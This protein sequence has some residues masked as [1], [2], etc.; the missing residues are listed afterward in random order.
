MAFALGTALLV[1][2]GAAAGVTIVE[3]QSSL[4]RVEHAHDVEVTLADLE[5]ALSTA[6]RAQTGYLTSGDPRFLDQYQTLTP[7][8]QPKLDHIRSLIQDIP[9]HQNW[10]AQLVLLANRRLSLMRA[11]VQKRESRKPGESDDDLQTELTRQRVVVADEMASLFQEMEKRERESSNRRVDISNL[12]LD[13]ILSILG[14]TFAMSIGLLYLNYRF[15][16]S[17]LADRL[18]A[19]K[20]ALESQESL[21]LL[22]T[23]LLHVQDEER[24]QFSREVHDSLGQYLNLVKMSLSALASKR[25]AA[26]LAESMEYL[27]RCIA[28]TR[29]ISYL[30]HPPLLDEMGFAFAAKWFL[31][32]FSQRSGIQVAAEIP[33]DM[34]RLPHPV[35]LTLFRVLQECL[36]NIHRHSGSPRADVAIERTPK[37]VTLRV[38]DYGNGISPE[39]LERFRTSGSHVGVGLAG[40]RERVREQGG[41]FD[42]ESADPGTIVTVQMAAETVASPARE[43]LLTRR[44]G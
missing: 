17:E 26:E 24:R 6:G 35:E 25:P 42:I 43:A 18:R 32:G 27:D 34:D 2:S 33:D 37:D 21:R 3:L 20:R 7:E 40:M 1:L 11:S 12:L 19:E 31:D 30:L 9:G 8:I 14:A 38:R 4:K 5:S 29:T 41:R 10:Y 23:R 22:S 13:A 28:E 44:S 39:L 16:R 15:L 36:T